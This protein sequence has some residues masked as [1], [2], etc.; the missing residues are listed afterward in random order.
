MSPC[1]GRKRSGVGGPLSGDGP[2][3]FVNMVTYG[4]AAIGGVAGRG[5][6]QSFG[7][8]IRLTMS[9]PE[10]AKNRTMG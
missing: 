3:V 6:A 7:N 8:R 9:E 2:H 5:T 10:T 4:H 1:I